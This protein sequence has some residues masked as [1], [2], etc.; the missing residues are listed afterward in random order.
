MNNTKDVA[1]VFVNSMELLVDEESNNDSKRKLASIQTITDLKPIPEAD[2]IEVASVLGWKVVVKKGEFK[3]GDKCIYC[4][5]DSI[6]PEAE[7]T[8]F[9]RKNNFRIKTIKLRGQISQGIC[10]PLNVLENYG[11]VFDENIWNEE[12]DDFVRQIDFKSTELI[13]EDKYLKC[14]YC[15]TLEDDT[16]LTEVLGIKKYVPN[17]FGDGGFMSGKFAGNFPSFL[18]KTDETRIQNLKSLVEQYEGTPIII[19]EKLDGCSA[20]YFYNNG[21]FGVCSRNRMVQDD[22]TNVYWKMAKKY[23]IENIL[24]EHGKNIAMQGEIIGSKIQGNKLRIY[25][26]DLKVFDLFNIDIG[27]YYDYDSCSDFINKYSLSS[28]PK[29]DELELTSDIDEW[30]KYSTR[31]SVLNEEVWAEGIVIRSKFNLPFNEF[32]FKKMGINRLSL[33][34]INPEFLLKYDKRN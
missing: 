11:Y 13:Q 8:E 22:D 5:I 16:D 24:R 25:D 7:W 21:E 18:I 10:F 31:K 6:L 34:V 33:K 26:I 27:I 1:D 29:L 2:A 17:T 20:T 4:E 3:V 12:A 19:T 28:V 14:K 9:L 30:V 15:F 32:L 23:D